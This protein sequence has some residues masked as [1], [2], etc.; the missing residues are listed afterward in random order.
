MEHS[1]GVTTFERHPLTLQD[2]RKLERKDTTIGLV[3]NIPGGGGGGIEREKRRDDQDEPRVRGMRQ[4][5]MS[6]T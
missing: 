3:T 1:S 2:A 5:D 4:G 6:R